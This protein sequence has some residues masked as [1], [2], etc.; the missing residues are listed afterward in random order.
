MTTT[1]QHDDPLV[2]ARASV[3]AHC[4]N[5]RYNLSMWSGE[6]RLPQARKK[7]RRDRRLPLRVTVT[8]LGPDG[9]EQRCE[10]SDVS[11]HGIRLR[12]KSGPP[13]GASVTLNVVLP[14]G[15]AQLL[16][17]VVHNDPIRQTLGLEFTE[18]ADFAMWRAWLA[19]WA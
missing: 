14:D 2:V 7:T 15:T 1:G 3:I 10:S 4:E 19:E 12:A 11:V 17:T 13:K 18:S 8:L 5:C 6:I 16:A 9:S